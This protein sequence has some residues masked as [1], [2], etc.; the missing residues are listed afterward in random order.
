M[1]EIL[2]A[3]LESVATNW[4]LVS[5]LNITRVLAGVVFEG[6]DG[7]NPSIRIRMNES[8]VIDTSTLTD[9]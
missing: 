9:K 4:S 2:T 1:Y 5:D 6:L 8:D 3:S 7:N